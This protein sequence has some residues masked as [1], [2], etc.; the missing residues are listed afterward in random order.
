MAAVVRR[1][2]RAAER[3]APRAAVVHGHEEDVGAGLVLAR[4]LLPSRC[5]VRR[6]RRPRGGE[7]ARRMLWRVALL[8]R[9]AVLRRRL[10]LWWWIRPLARRKPHSHPSVRLRDADRRN[11]EHRKPARRTLLL[12][13]RMIVR[14]LLV[15]LSYCLAIRRR[16]SVVVTHLEQEASGAQRSRARAA[17]G[18]FL[19]TPQL[20]DHHPW[21]LVRPN[22]LVPSMT[23]LLLVRC[24]SERAFRRRVD[25]RKLPA[26]RVC[27]RAT[28]RGPFSALSGPS[29]SVSMC[30][31]CSLQS[32]TLLWRR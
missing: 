9:I 18:H 30:A 10:V 4:H 20:A 16:R 12:V 23:A 2:E 29:R 14:L 31:L 21:E 13:L 3:T 6:R 28:L 22:R 25:P 7:S 32:I 5:P 1:V 24:P 11:P 27:P 15:L 17:A 26:D 19:P 8:R